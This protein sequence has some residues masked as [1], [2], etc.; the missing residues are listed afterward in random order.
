MY[1]RQISPE[2]KAYQRASQAAE[3]RRKVT[4]ELSGQHKQEPITE[5]PGR[6]LVSVMRSVMNSLRMLGSYFGLISRHT[7][8]LEHSVHRALKS[9]ASSIVT[10]TADV[11]ANWPVPLAACGATPLAIR[12]G[13]NWRG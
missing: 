8:R 13:A 12:R 5:V 11:S 7:L 6:G 10:R 1:R 3:V 2:A 4:R 9:G